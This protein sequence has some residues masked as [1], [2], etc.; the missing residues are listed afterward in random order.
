[1]VRRARQDIAD[2]MLIYRG[3]KLAA[4]AAKRLES[5]QQQRLAAFSEVTRSLLRKAFS[6]ELT[7]DKLED[8]VAEVTA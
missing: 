8:A 5:I 2:Y 4:L 6:G 3:Q 7:S 1:V